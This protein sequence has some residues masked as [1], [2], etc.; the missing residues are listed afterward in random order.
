MEQLRT[1]INQKE[2]PNSTFKPS[3]WVKFTPYGNF[4]MLN[5]TIT[6]PLDPGFDPIVNRVFDY[7]FRDNG[8]VGVEIHTKTRQSVSV[9]GL[10]E[11]ATEREV[12]F[13]IFGE[14]LEKDLRRAFEAI[15]E[16]YFDLRGRELSREILGSY[17]SDG[18]TLPD[19]IQ[20]A[21]NR[22]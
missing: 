16:S 12:S 8:T 18:K 2:T 5:V 10:Q 11:E 13:S 7:T 14:N 19:K 4:G 6:Y 17:E 1:Y 9:L 20:D 21:M 15:E 3:T 22:G